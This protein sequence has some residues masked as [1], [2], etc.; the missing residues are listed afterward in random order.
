MSDFVLSRVERRLLNA[1]YC[2]KL[3]GPHHILNMWQDMQAWLRL[4][5]PK[6]PHRG[7]NVIL[8]LV[9]QDR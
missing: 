6:G 5:I 7:E 4:L 9:N 3:G 2:N 1:Y 8:V